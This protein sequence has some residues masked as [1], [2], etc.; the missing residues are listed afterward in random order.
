[1]PAATEPVL[2]AATAEP[3]SVERR[4]VG[5]DDPG[6]AEQLYDIDNALSARFFDSLVQAEWRKEAVP[7]AQVVLRGPVDEAALQLLDAAPL[8][9]E[10]VIVTDGP[11]WDESNAVLLSLIDRL[12]ADDTTGPI[13]GHY[14][15]V[16]GVYSVSY[17]APG[18][19]D[20]DALAGLTGGATVELW[21]GGSEVPP[22]SGPQ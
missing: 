1:M 18:P 14:D 21:Y 6:I 20:P 13:G 22:D 16:E 17:V 12:R 15:E 4:I 9:V 8:Q 7:H 19:I 2:I 5:A 10:V 3:P 11:T